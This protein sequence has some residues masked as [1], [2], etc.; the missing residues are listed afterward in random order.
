MKEAEY[1]E[2][3]ALIEAEQFPSDHLD[4]L[5]YAI[6]NTIFQ[7]S[8]SLRLIE[9]AEKSDLPEGKIRAAIFQN[10]LETLRKNRARMQKLKEEHDQGF[11]SHD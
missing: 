10:R 7:E 1:Q 4:S 5:D 9:L 11:L 2:Q 3:V 8:K 6:L